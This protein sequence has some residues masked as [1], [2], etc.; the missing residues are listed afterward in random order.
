MVAIPP[1][2]QLVWENKIFTFRPPQR[3]STY[4]SLETKNLLAWTKK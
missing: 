2:Y 3:D 1:L 4:V